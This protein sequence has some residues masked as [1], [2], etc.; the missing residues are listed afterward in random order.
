VSALSVVRQAARTAIQIVK[1]KGEGGACSTAALP[2]PRGAESMWRR[3]RA[4]GNPYDPSIQNIL[5]GLRAWLAVGLGGNCGLFRPATRDGAALS[6][7]APA[8]TEPDWPARGRP[9]GSDR[10]LGPEGPQSGRLETCALTG[11]P[12]Y[13]RTLVG[14]GASRSA[15]TLGCT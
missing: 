13:R 6:P 2:R 3:E 4:D 15:S 11:T 14:S 8:S 5:T 9:E 1:E 7:M 10:S 12:A